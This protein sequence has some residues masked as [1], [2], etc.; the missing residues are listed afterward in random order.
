MAYEEKPSNL[1][2]FS[3]SGRAPLVETTPSFF[4]F[5]W[6]KPATPVGG[7]EANSTGITLNATEEPWGGSATGIPLTIGSA[8][9]AWNNAA[10]INFIAD[11]EPDA[12]PWN[13]GVDL[14]FG[15]A[16][17]KEPVNL[18]AAVG[19][20]ESLG[21]T[22][23]SPM[24]LGEIEFASGETV[25]HTSPVLRDTRN[26]PDVA[27][28]VS[29]FNQGLA[30][31]ASIR[32]AG[33]WPA[34]YTLTSLWRHFYTLAFGVPFTTA[35]PTP[36][37]GPALYSGSPELIFGASY[38]AVPV[39]TGTAPYLTTESGET[40]GASLSLEFVGLGHQY[41]HGE[42]LAVVF[43]TDRILDWAG[44]GGEALSVDLQVES[45]RTDCHVG[46][47]VA[48]TLDVYDLVGGTGRVGE[49]VEAS[50]ATTSLLQATGQGGE[51]LGVV[52]DARP[53][54]TPATTVATGESFTF[55]VYTS[56][57]LV[58]SS[59]TGESL[60][61]VLEAADR[62]SL[63]ATAPVG[64]SAGVDLQISFAFPAIS[65]ATGPALSIDS[66]DEV[67][68]YKAVTGES[69]EVSV[70]TAQSLDAWGSEGSRLDAVLTTVG[71]KTLDMRFTTGESVESVA[72]RVAV[73]TRLEVVVFEG[74]GV[75]ATESTATTSLDLEGDPL[76]YSTVIPWVL[77]SNAVE[78]EEVPPSFV[79][80]RGT[81]TRLTVSLSTRPRLSIHMATGEAFT[82]SSQHRYIE[83]VAAYGE[84][85]K[86][87]EWL[88]I[89]PLTALCYPNS[90]PNPDAMEVELEVEET[91]CASDYTYTGET[92]RAG[93]ATVKT[94]VPSG[95]YGEH[96]AFDFVI[97]KPFAVVIPVM[98]YVVATLS[99]QPSM[100]VVMHDGVSWKG[101][102]E[103][104][105]VLASTGEVF[106]AA[107]HTTVD[108]EFL[109]TGC[110]PNDHIWVDENGDAVR[111]LTHGVGVEGM[112]FSHDLKARCF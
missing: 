101:T 57:I 9:F 20:G 97:E 5:S 54:F 96:L 55:A 28:D 30:F 15:Q 75:T 34:S 61:V 14:P 70:V 42:V 8:R 98:Q 6:I 77:E 21:A 111:D 94:Y 38:P 84:G 89:E 99:T 29:P 108:V 66:L 60:A 39:Y 33:A 105:S 103:E 92:L 76:C 10:D 93:L 79:Y 81:D 43:A 32:S 53:L 62:A 13:D 104:P 31:R 11:D 24:L 73:S 52:L 72:P 67:P 87:A 2:D 109:E 48:V 17:Y 41:H 100:S 112:E 106:T 3:W 63:V 47:S 74:L 18:D 58:P 1:V 23:A 56:V 85:V 91:S 78:M 46:E 36:L 64:E 44:R 35:Q 82:A 69:L 51:E 86:T 19:V 80:Q 49:S 40:L 68:N 16:G 27:G 22:L 83:A 26:Y 110:L 45:A 65:A 7:V 71:A 37:V 12:A 107:L 88:Y 95:A 4:N 90:F 102:M 50:L 59:P 25:G